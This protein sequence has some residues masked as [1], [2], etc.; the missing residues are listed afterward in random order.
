[1]DRYCSIRLLLGTGLALSACAAYTDH[2]R[3]AT[4][5]QAADPASWG[6]PP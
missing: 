1:M 2:F 5:Y 3:I 6:T 4:S